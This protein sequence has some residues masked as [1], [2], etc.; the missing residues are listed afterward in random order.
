MEPG[1]DN[2][3]SMRRVNKQRNP[4]WFALLSCYVQRALGVSEHIV[5]CKKKKQKPTSRRIIIKLYYTSVAELY[6]Y[7]FLQTQI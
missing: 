1:L 3:H 6:F 5:K 7:S 4:T 2:T